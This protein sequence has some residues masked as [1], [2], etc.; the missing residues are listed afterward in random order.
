MIILATTGLLVGIILTFS[1]KRWVRNTHF[2][3]GNDSSVGQRLTMWSAAIKA[4]SDA[5][6]F[7]SGVTE[8]LTL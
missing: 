2:F 3:K 7:G 6:I 8:N 4:I 1:Y 5:F